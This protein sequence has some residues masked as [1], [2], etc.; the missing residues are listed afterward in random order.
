MWAAL[1]P[2]IVS[3]I[4]EVV[5]D[6]DKQDEI[7][8]KI[9]TM[10]QTHAHENAKAQ[11]EVNATEATHRSIFVAGWRP[12]IGWTCGVAMFSNFIVAPYVSAFTSTAIPTL[13][14]AEMMPVLVG[15]LGLGAYRSYEK[16]K[17]VAK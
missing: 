7:A 15:M 17:G 10:A 2:S 12:F 8:H 1:I 11:I 9:A 4:S 3:L 5:P 13:E 14:L 6:R 16:S